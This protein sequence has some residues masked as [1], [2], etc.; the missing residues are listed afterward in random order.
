MSIHCLDSR[1]TESGREGVFWDDVNC[2][3]ESVKKGKKRGPLDKYLRKKLLGCEEVKSIVI[4]Y[5][6]L[7]LSLTIY[8]DVIILQKV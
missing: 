5:K 2:L 8:H 4:S 3:V 7:K 1:L 6:I